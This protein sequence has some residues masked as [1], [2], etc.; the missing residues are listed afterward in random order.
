MEHCRGILPLLS[1]LLLSAAYSQTP[2]L[3]AWRSSSGGLNVI[4][5]MDLPSDL[6]PG[7]I[8]E[9]ELVIMDDPEDGSLL[10]IVGLDPGGAEDLG[11]VDFPMFMNPVKTMVRFDDAT[12]L[13]V[14]SSQYPGRATMNNASYSWDSALRT[15]LPEETWISD[16]SEEIMADADSLLARG[17]IRE[18]ADTLSGMSYYFQYV[19]ADQMCP[20]FLRAAHAASEQARRDGR[21]QDALGSYDD[22]F[23]AFGTMGAR[24]DW[25][26]SVDSRE[27]Y[28]ESPYSSFMDPEE[29]S[30][31]LDDFADLFND[32]DI[33]A[34]AVL[35]TISGILKEE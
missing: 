4:R 33:A 1:L 8:E 21:T 7:G 5:V 9:T 6:L 29:L 32:N 13:I 26:L 35:E 22:A 27:E 2:V 25:F 31:I 12:G 34:G 16:R 14:V 11:T 18:A 17:M 10:G 15:L 23:Y 30:E 28:L 3:D 24:Q 19:N 20:R